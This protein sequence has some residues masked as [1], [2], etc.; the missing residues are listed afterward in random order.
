M[1][2][3]VSD[4]C[5]ASIC[6]CN[7]AHHSVLALR[8]FV[9]FSFIP[10]Y[11]NIGLQIRSRLLPSTSISIQYSRVS[12]YSSIFTCQSLFFNFHVSVFILQY[13]RVSLYSSI[14][15]Y[16]SLFFSIHVS[17][18]ILQY[19]CVSLYSSIF[20]CQSLFFNIH[21][22][23]FILQYSRVSLYSSIFTC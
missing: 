20:T 11:F 8:V 16:Q 15:T 7:I 2:Y 12:L 14:F 17:V 18:V 4:D 13:S 19:S 5:T 6:N 21:V 3:Y 10:T 9:T 1:V 22:S 23:V